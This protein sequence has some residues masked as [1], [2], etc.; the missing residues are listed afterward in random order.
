M[1]TKNS[2]PSFN[3]S[4]GR[5]QR[6]LQAWQVLI[7]CAANRQTITYE[8]LGYAMF[9]KKAAGV[10][11]QIL[12]LVAGY[13]NAHGLPP[14]TALVVQSRHGKPGT[15]ILLPANEDMDVLREKV[16]AAPWFTLLPPDPSQLGSK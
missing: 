12:D 13:C 10:L 3:P 4:S 14:L 2:L 9:G 6:A 15:G 5:P 16:F 7:S 11:A 8:Q 1:A